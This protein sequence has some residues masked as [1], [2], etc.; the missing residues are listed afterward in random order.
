MLANQK[1]SR[2]DS[3][4]EG[5][6]KSEIPS[7]RSFEDDNSININYDSSIHHSNNF[8]RMSL[9]SSTSALFGWLGS[10]IILRSFPSTVYEYDNVMNGINYG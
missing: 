2:D 7:S 6:K 3:D 4:N 8:F 9:G 5:G 10:S 1:S